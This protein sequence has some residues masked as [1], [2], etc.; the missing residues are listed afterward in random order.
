MPSATPRS[1][2]ASKLQAHRRGKQA[3]A[4][5]AA[6]KTRA[7]LPDGRPRPAQQSVEMPDNGPRPAHLASHASAAQFDAAQ[8]EK[9]SMETMQDEQHEAAAKLQAIK[10]GQ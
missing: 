8:L 9:L 5:V 2:A 10:R 3:R 1:E 6:K 7:K 4:Q